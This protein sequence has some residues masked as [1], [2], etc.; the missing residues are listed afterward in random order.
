MSN[1]IVCNTPNSERQ[2]LGKSALYQ[3]P[4]CGS[5]ALSISA[6]NVL[7]GQLNEVPIR[8]SIM[9]HALRRMQ[10]PNGEHLTT[11]TSS[12][13]SSFWRIRLPT[14]QQQADNLVLWIGDNQ[15]TASDYAE[16]TPAALG[17]TIGTAISRRGE[18]GFNWLNSQLESDRLYVLAER[19]NGKIALG[20]TMSGWHRYGALKKTTS[21]SRT[22]FIAMKFGQAELNRV[23]E[24][25]FR[26]AVRR[27]GFELRVLTDEQPAGI[28][29][30][31][32][33][34]AII[35]ARFVIADLTHGS[36]GAYWEAGFAEGLN[37]PV[38]YTCE[39]IQWEKAKTHFDTNH[40]VTIVWD[41]A[42]LRAAEDALVST[43]RAT[44]RSEA[45]QSDD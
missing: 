12:E 5:F 35:A 33:R 6:E 28:I 13:I 36:Q 8:R 45:K 9:S 26:P 3:C 30:D 40:L 15:I 18:D 7:P 4:R 29:D 38:I 1:C 24:Q 32:M 44:L 27:T 19:P 23:V 42:N 16:T 21:E 22:A 14:P 31:Q 25:C 20:L 2:G 41:T 43:I 37:L 11:I 39:K 17:A 34:A 10:R